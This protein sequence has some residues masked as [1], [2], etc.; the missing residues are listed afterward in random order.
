[1]WQWPA[2][3]PFPRPLSTKMTA[4]SAGLRPGSLGG[5]VGGG[6]RKGVTLSARKVGDRRLLQ[7]VVPLQSAL[8]CWAR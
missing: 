7:L 5:P 2:Q 6:E 8:P 4:R 1:M 3:S